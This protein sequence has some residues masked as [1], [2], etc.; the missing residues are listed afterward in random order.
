MKILVACVV[1][2]ASVSAPLLADNVVYSSLPSG[3]YYNVPSLGFEATSTA[4]FGQGVSI[5]TS[6]ALTAAQILM[7]DWALES[8]YE[9]VGLTTGFD[10]PLTLT[11]YTVGSSNSVGAVIWS[12]TIDAHIL[13]RPE[14]SAGCG[15]AWRAADG[16]CYNGLAQTVTFPMDNVVVPSDFIWGLA[17]NTTDYGASP[18]HVLGP[19]DSLNVGTSGGASIG[20][21]LVVA[22]AFLNSGWA[23]AYGDLGAGGTGTFRL[24]P[25]GWAGYDPAAEFDAIP[26]PGSFGMMIGAALTLGLVFVRR[27]RQSPQR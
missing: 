21:D 7:S 24:D 14:A 19:Y 18:T 13:W 16:N 1:V 10:V 5:G 20:S 17:F 25:I 3:T 22:S 6:T 9:G 12:G 27:R 2:L 4:E 23:G 26:E 11:L 15:T 8:T